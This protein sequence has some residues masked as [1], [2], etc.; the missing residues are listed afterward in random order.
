MDPSLDVD[1]LEVVQRIRR[2]HLVV[3]RATEEHFA[4]RGLSGPAFAVLSVL[5]RQPGRGVRQGHL[6]DLLHLTPGTVSLRIDQLVEDG[7]VERSPD[8]GDRRSSLVALTDDGR[9]RFNEVAGDHLALQDQFL[10]ALTEVERGTL[11]DL[12]RKLLVSYEPRPDHCP[13]R[14]IGLELTP[15]RE[16]LALQRRLGAAEQVGLLVAGVEQASRAAR[17]G[18]REGDLIVAAGRRRLRSVVDLVHA[19]ETDAASPITVRRGDAEVDLDLAVDDLATDD[20][21]AHP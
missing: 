18:L 19:L 8:P 16:V 15:A 1:P 13:T 4:R 11:A 2:V 14:R 7:L 21:G 17:A 10:A 20:L 3:A 12:L 5:M 9:R 6:A